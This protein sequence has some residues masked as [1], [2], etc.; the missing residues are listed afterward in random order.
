MER[1]PLSFTD[2]SDSEFPVQAKGNKGAPIYQPKLKKRSGF[3]FL[4]IHTPIP[5][6]EDDQSFRPRKRQFWLVIVQFVVIFMLKIFKEAYLSTWNLYGDNADFFAVLTV[7]LCWQFSNVAHNSHNLAATKAY[8]SITVM[9][10]WLWFCAWVLFFLVIHETII[11]ADISKEDF[12][13]LLDCYNME[14][15]TMGLQH[16]D[17]TMGSNL[18]TRATG[19]CPSLEFKSESKG[20]AWIFFQFCISFF[21]IIS[22]FINVVDNMKVMSV[23]TDLNKVEADKMLKVANLI[24]E[25]EKARPAVTDIPGAARA[26]RW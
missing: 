25:A 9:A 2:E 19:T 18:K 11:C 6:S 10:A 14:P 20:G 17:C 22:L 26:A 1:K 5:W 24:E 3:S 8:M 21:L 7:F 4:S 16:A 12:K 13:V 15:Q 23:L